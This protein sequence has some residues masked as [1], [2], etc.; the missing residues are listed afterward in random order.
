LTAPDA[1]PGTARNPRYYDG[2]ADVVG[3]VHLRI[4][5]FAYE[6]DEGLAAG[7]NNEPLL[8]HRPPG[9]GCLAGRQRFRFRAT[10]DETLRRFRDVFIPTLKRLVEKS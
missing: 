8:H 6:T 2:P 9:P 4:R 3:D 7:R 5:Y 10:A 1:P